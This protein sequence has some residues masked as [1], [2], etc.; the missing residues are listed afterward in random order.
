MYD[1][2]SSSY[3]YISL[4][5]ACL[6]A[7]K[8]LPF[9]ILHEIRRRWNYC[10]SSFFCRTF[11]YYNNSF[12]FALI[13]LLLCICL[14]KWKKINHPTEPIEKKTILPFIYLRNSYLSCTSLNY[15]SAKSYF[16]FICCK[17]KFYFWIGTGICNYKIARRRIDIWPLLHCFSVGKKR[18]KRCGQ[19]RPPSQ[20]QK[21]NCSSEIA[22][23]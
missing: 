19:I 11:L 2:R 1:L 9:W 7:C 20:V 13:S 22:K 15:I 17:C 8:I 16:H 23:K 4:R 21:R 3:T 5:S 14:S 18:P 12:A 10:V 6:Q